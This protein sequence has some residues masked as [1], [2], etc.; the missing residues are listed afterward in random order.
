MVV[1]T[2]PPLAESQNIYFSNRL[3]YEGLW[4]YDDRLE[5]CTMHCHIAFAVSGLRSKEIIKL[6]E[7]SLSSLPLYPGSNK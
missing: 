6:V 7:W 5:L 3:L 1:Q 2:K 4:Q